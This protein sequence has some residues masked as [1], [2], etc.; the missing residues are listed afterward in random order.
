VYALL[1]IVPLAVALL[2]APTAAQ[3]LIACVNTKNGG[4]RLV[5][6][7]ADCNASKE[8]AVSWNVVGP[9]GP[10]GDQGEPGPQGPPGPP[11]R[12]FDGEGNVLGIPYTGAVL[13]NEQIG[14]TV[15]YSTLRGSSSVANLHFESFDCSGAGFLR[16]N[17]GISRADTLLGPFPAPFPSYFAAPGTGALQTAVLQ[18][19]LTSDSCQQLCGAGGCEEEVQDLLPAVPF[20]GTLPFTIPVP[21]P[22]HVGIGQ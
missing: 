9:E 12:V 8:T 17:Q 21:E 13:F 19:T 2:A 10:Q 14:L 7:P 11:L 18:T 5:G 3:Q 6:S 15:W 22:I 20:S 16:I 4:M 1:G